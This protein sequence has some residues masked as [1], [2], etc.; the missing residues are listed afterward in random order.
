MNTS[1]STDRLRIDPLTRDDADL[2]VAIFTDP[3]VC[4]HVGG[5]QKA[6]EIL[7]DMDDTTRRGGNGCIGVWCMRDEQGE[8]LGTLALLPMPID[9]DETD[10]SL[11]REGEWPDAIIEIG[12]FLKN[13]A[14]G[15]GYVTEGARALINEVFSSESLDEIAATTAPDNA[16]SLNVLRK[17]GFE[18]VGPRRAYGHDGPFFLLK[19]SNWKT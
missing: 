5:P 15:K 18:D 14:Q 19:R 10:W 16:E 17:L 4:R 6:Q 1:F 11:V 9:Q 13:G 8:K 2:V 12:Y 7:D 3:E